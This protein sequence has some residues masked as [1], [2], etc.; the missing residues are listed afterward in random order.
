MVAAHIRTADAAA[1]GSMEEDRAEEVEEDSC[2]AECRP[3]GGRG[4]LDGD[5]AT[6]RDCDE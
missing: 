4:R 5:V 6:H 3:S 1:D 2:I